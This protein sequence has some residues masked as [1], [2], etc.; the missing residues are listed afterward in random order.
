[1]VALPRFEYPH[2]GLPMEQHP[3]IHPHCHSHYDFLGHAHSHSHPNSS[4]NHA[5]PGT[6]TSRRD[7]LR[8][9][10]GGAFAG[11]SVLELAFHRAAWARAA[12]TTT[13][14]KLFDLQKVVDGVFFAQARPQAAI[15]CN[16]AIFVRSKDVVVVDA[17]SKPSA[18]AALIAQLKR[19][20]TSKPV[21]YV[22]N[23][24]FHWDHTQGNHAYRAAA[25]EVD[26]IATSTT[27]KL[28][29]DLASARTKAL[30]DDL[31]N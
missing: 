12:S 13:D 15:N 20:V 27:S 7:F 14:A 30:L 11:A 2:V 5:H 31:P 25:Q 28:L 8:V 23:T 10:M 16:A 21:R 17:H 6:G 19:D 3:H 26:F 24:H 29:T 22:I 9:L 4:T 1:M 18:A